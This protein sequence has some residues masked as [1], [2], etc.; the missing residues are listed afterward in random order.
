MH[1]N[2]CLFF[3]L[4]KDLIHEN[5]QFEPA[6]CDLNAL[7]RDAAVITTAHNLH[8]DVVAEYLTGKGQTN[9]QIAEFQ[10]AILKLSL[11]FSFDYSNKKSTILKQ[12]HF[13]LLR[14]LNSAIHQIVKV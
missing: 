9:T 4:S 11:A 10:C 2:I 8:L 14:P 5:S 13:G 6:V 3:R 1:A 7:C 12:T